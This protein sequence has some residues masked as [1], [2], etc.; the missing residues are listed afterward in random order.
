[1]NISTL[2]YYLTSQFTCKR[3]YIKQL[4]QL[5]ESVETENVELVRNGKALYRNIITQMN[6]LVSYLGYSN[7]G[8]K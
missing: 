7:V 1:M 5:H 4:H 3:K 6:Y 2:T 8:V